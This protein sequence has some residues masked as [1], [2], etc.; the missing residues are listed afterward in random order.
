MDSSFSATS[1]RGH[2]SN[3]FQQGRDGDG[4][5][6]TDDC[7]RHSDDGG[8]QNRHKLASQGRNWGGGDPQNNLG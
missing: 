8:D 1:R 5:L 7:Q 2:P 4:H 3:I 6:F